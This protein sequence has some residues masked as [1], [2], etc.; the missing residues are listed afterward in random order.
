M[1]VT[2][3]GLIMRI[4]IE[5]ICMLYI[6]ENTNVNECTFIENTGYHFIPNFGPPKRYLMRLSNKINGA[7]FH[8][9]DM[10]RD[11]T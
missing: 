10:I 5:S 4:E 6:M 11:R 8:Y 7:K 2:T 9:V 1:D 3:L